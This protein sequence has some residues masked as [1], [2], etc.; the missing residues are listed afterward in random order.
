MPLVGT[1]KRKDAQSLREV[2]RRK[3]QKRSASC[4]KRKTSTHNVHGLIQTL[5]RM[6][7]MAATME[8]WQ[9]PR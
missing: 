3:M 8:T 2:K 4:H 7:R 9:H 1:G 5:Q 6:R